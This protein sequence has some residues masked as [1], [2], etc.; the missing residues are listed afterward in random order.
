MDPII[1][2]LNKQPIIPFELGH[3]EKYWTKRDAFVYMNCDKPVYRDTP[4]RV[5]GFQ[6]VK[7]TPLTMKFYKQYLRYAQ[8]YRIITDSINQCRKPNYKGFKQHRHDQSIFSL[9]SKKY[10]FAAYSD[11]SQFGNGK[12]YPNYQY[13][14]IINLTRNKK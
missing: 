2:L 14:Q 8:D 6:L 12:V 9:L 7:K 5:G 4:M 13:P 1:E 10:G 11:P 3:I